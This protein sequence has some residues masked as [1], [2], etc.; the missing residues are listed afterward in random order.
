VS[1]C[2]QYLDLDHNAVPVVGS[3]GFGATLIM[4]P[5]AKPDGSDHRHRITG[6]PDH[7]ITD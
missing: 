6:S 2:R 3:V 7:R 5:R 1:A 4:S